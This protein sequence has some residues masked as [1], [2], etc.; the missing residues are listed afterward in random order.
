MHGFL[1]CN[2]YSTYVRKDLNINAKTGEAT[3]SVIFTQGGAKS[4]IAVIFEVVPEDERKQE[5]LNIAADLGPLLDDI[6]GFISIERF[7]S[8]TNPGKILSLSFWRDEASVNQW[9]QMEQHR[10]AQI[11]GRTLIFKDYRLRVAGVLR[12]Y[13]LFDRDQAPADSQMFHPCQEARLP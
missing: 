13:G 5:Y 2:L 9:R 12:D 6:D 3:N 4:M 11:Q 7:E 8:L 10:T 1:C